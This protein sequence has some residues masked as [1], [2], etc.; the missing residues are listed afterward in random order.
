TFHDL[1]AHLDALPEEEVKKRLAE[2]KDC[3]LKGD[4]VETRI[5]DELSSTFITPL[6]REDIHLM[7]IN[8]DRCLDIVNT[9]SSKMDAYGIRKVPANVR[10]FVDIIVEISGQLQ[11]LVAAL[12]AKS[13]VSDIAER[14]H[15]LENR[16][17]YLFQLSMAELFREETN[18]IKI[19]K[20]K[21]VYE[22]L[23]AVVDAVDYIGK[24]VRGVMVKH[25]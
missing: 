19:I 20:F 10:N 13:D 25:G 5:I 14:M 9:I 6:D 3:E 23:E 2:I 4:E 17:D 8:I 12:S 16:A 11:P 7:A 24:I 1:I 21:E 15:G 22:H 18:P